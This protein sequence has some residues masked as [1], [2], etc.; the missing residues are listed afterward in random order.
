MICIYWIPQI[1]WITMK[2][3]VQFHV[4]QQAF[5]HSA[6]PDGGVLAYRFG[7]AVGWVGG[8][9]RLCVNYCIWFI[10]SKL[11]SFVYT[12]SCALSGSFAHLPHI[13]LTH[14]PITWQIWYQW[15]SHFEERIYISETAGGIF[16]IRSSIE[17]SRPVVV[18]RQDHLPIRPMWACPLGE[19][20][21]YE[22]AARIPRA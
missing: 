17:L 18:Q 11:D 14:G 2:I 21:I 19:S 22:T 13:M 9:S 10:H 4:T 8:C 3:H 1:T 5:Y 12:C 20:L 7:Q 16:S 15:G 6:L